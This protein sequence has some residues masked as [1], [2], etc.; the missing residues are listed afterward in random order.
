ANANGPNGAASGIEFSHLSIGFS[1]TPERVI[2]RDG[3]VRGSSLAATVDGA[4][5]YAGNDMGLRG[6]FVPLYGVTPTPGL[7]P[8][9]GWMLGA[10]NN[11]GVLALTFEVT[12]PVF[13]PVLR[14]NPISAVA[15]GL[16]RKVL[17]AR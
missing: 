13:A 11:Q 10:G 14:I 5:D 12:G 6:T 15:P 7:I 17:Q 3:I 4:I 1:R 8:V 9:I 2:L 16:L